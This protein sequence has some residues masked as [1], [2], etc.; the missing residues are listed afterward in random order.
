MYD[1]WRRRRVLDLYI[2]SQIKVANLKKLQ[3]FS[4]G[5]FEY[6]VARFIREVRKVSGEEFPPATL[7]EI[8]IMLQMFLHENSAN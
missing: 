3:T 6:S 7:Y 1:D 2:P 5:N 4:Q 8:V